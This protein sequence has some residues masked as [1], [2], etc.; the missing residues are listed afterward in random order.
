VLKKALSPQFKHRG[1]DNVL[2]AQGY[3]VNKKQMSVEGRRLD[4]FGAPQF[5]EDTWN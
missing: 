3:R 4:K 2:P 5:F 1:N